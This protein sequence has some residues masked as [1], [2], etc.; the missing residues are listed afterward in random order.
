M[1]LYLLVQPKLKSGHKPIHSGKG[2]ARLPENLYLEELARRGASPVSEEEIEA[3]YHDYHRDY[4]AGRRWF[5]VADW[6]GGPGI[7]PVFIT[8]GISGFDLKE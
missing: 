5:E 8:A 2:K 7:V 4:Q 3:S 6:F 1:R